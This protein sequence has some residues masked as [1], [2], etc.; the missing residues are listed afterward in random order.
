MVSRPRTP[1]PT[2][3]IK[4]D[5]VGAGS[6]L[7][8]VDCCGVSLSGSLF[9][10]LVVVPS[11][12]WFTS[13]LVW[14]LV[15]SFFSILSRRCFLLA[16]RDSFKSSSSSSSPSSALSTATRTSFLAAEE[17]TMGSVVAMPLLEVFV[18]FFLAA[19]TGFCIFFRFL[20][21]PLKTGTDSE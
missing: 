13:D 8:I 2:G 20:G 9:F 16:R 12:S 4:G 17:G 11:V 1:L 18:L 6:I 7:C 3:C 5:K 14:F 19:G 15:V 21:L 10:A